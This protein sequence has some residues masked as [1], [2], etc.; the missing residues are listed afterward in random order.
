MNEEV[1]LALAHIAGE[2]WGTHARAVLNQPI[3][4]PSAAVP[5]PVQPG[6]LL[7]TDAYFEILG[8]LKA[9]F[10]REVTVDGDPTKVDDGQDA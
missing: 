6:R 10:K 8:R 3:I 5:Q 4:Q 2:V 1:Y 7:G 9:D